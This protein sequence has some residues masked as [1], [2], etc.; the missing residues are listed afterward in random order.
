VPG[1]TAAFALDP[2][3]VSA[4]A[5][6]G[7]VTLVGRAPGATSVVVIVGDR[8][9]SFQ[10][11]VED[12]PTIYRPGAADARSIGAESGHYELRYGSDPRLLYGNLR[13]SRREGDRSTELALGGA[14]PFG[15]TA[16]SPF[17]IPLASFTL[18][19]PG[20]ELTLLDRVVT[21]SP[22]TVSRSTI[23]GVHLQQGPW[24]AHAGYSFF[25]NFEHL[26]LPTTRETV[27]GIGYRYAMTPRSSLTPNVYYFAGSPVQDGSGPLGTLVYETR[28]AADLT[29]AAELAV[30][31]ALGGAIELDFDRPDQRAW[32]KLRFAP[33]GVP[34]LS[35]DRQNGRHLEGGWTRRGEA[36][37]VHATASSRSYTAGTFGQSSTVGSLD[38]QRRLTGTWAIH[39][40]SGYSIFESASPLASPVHSLT[41]PA[42]ISFSRRHVGAGID[43]QFSRETTRNLAGHLVRANVNATGG[44]FRFSIHGERETHA[45][46]ARY[47]LSEVPWLQP[48]LDRL[49]LAA[50]TPQQL[51]DLLSTNADLSAFGYPTAVSIDITPVRS[52]A[53]ASAGWSGSG[54]FAPQLFASTLVNRDESVDRT[55]LSAVHSLTYSQRL[56]G[57]TEVFLTWSALCGGGDSLSSSCRPAMFASLRRSLSSAPGILGRRQGSIQGTVFQDDQGRGAY[58]PDMPVIPG[59]EVVLDGVRRTR[60]DA[61]GRFHFDDVPYGRH[62]VEAQYTGDQPTF[63]TTPSPAEVEVDASVDFGIGRAFSSVRGF[64][65]TD[66][67]AAVSGVVLRVS[68]PD[69]AITARTGDDGSFV[70]EGLPAGTYEVA[71]EPGSVPAGYAVDALLPQRVIVAETTAGR[72]GFVLQPYRTVS[73]R[74]RLFDR[75]KG[76]YVALAH[77]PVELQPLGRQ[78]I[79]D[80]DGSYAF[81]DL[82]AGAY[83]VVTTQGGQQHTAR[84]VVPEGPSLVKDVDVAVVPPAK[85]V[86]G[87]LLASASPARTNPRA[88]QSERPASRTT[89]AATRGASSSADTPAGGGSF[90]IEV[91]ESTSARHARKMV[92]ELKDA[93]H[94]AYLIE[95]A[96]TRRTASYHVFVGHYTTLAEANQSARSLEKTLGWRLHVTA[97]MAARPPTLVNRGKAVSYVP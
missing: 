75:E 77:A 63:F 1:A 14:A 76:Q 46:T 56:G 53:G 8:T 61:S 29:F 49:G 16:V 65:R 15:D 17:S 48:M 21:N 27:A 90:T 64:V 51:A 22:L 7:V 43:Y 72:A 12:P 19:T 3:R 81:R 52:R 89:T 39:G 93:G 37:N 30:G 59:V 38:V 79:T 10:V 9:E 94:A 78:S 97:S 70:A 33:A 58:S 55:A 66:A 80:A 42:G 86:E 4:S 24:R 41:L 13:L 91:A 44:A 87:A 73:G 28:P 95:P 60:T 47:I 96:G 20:R 31:R 26:L 23:R 40:G 54:P 25:G 2:S 32:T 34:S 88:T 18:R 84:V 69:R 67:G 11:L 50:Q 36:L 85:G 83:T 6:D 5:R 68:G 71:V 92:D 35:T 62:H 74:A 57:A 82:P 45:P